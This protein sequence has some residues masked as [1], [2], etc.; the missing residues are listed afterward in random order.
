VA[1]LGFKE[2]SSA[3]FKT[4]SDGIKSIFGRVSEGG[5]L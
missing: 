3:I 5:E 1:C 4:I 2:D